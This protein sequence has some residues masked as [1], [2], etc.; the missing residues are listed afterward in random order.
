MSIEGYTRFLIGTRLRLQSV[1]R[2]VQKAES[3]LALSHGESA[4]LE[5]AGSVLVQLVGELLE[6]E[7]HYATTKKISLEELY[8]RH[9]PEG[10]V[11]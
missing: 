7:A 5:S 4:R 8:A 6:R 11:V 2:D 9:S 10:R 1:L 3:A